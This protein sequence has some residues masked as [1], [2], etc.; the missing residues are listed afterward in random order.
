MIFCR[1]GGSSNGADIISEGFVTI[2]RFLV[3]APSLVLG[4][5]LSVLGASLF[6]LWLTDL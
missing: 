6:L 5:G 2:Y 4:A 1:C 3:S